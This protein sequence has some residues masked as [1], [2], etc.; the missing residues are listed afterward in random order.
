MDVSFLRP[1]GLG[2]ALER[3]N[4]GFRVKARV[5][6]EEPSLNISGVI[7]QALNVA[8]VCSL[9]NKVKHSQSRSSLT[10]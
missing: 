2:I 5:L 8:K 10:Q 6:Q 7:N 3:F 1:R 4:G 9:L